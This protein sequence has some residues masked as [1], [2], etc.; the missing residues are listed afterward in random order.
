MEIILENVANSFVNGVLDQKELIAIIKKH[1]PTAISLAFCYTSCSKLNDILRAG[2]IYSFLI[3]DQ[4][5]RDVTGGKVFR[6]DDTQREIIEKVAN[7][8]PRYV[9]LW[10]SSGTGKTLTAFESLTIMVTSMKERTPKKINVFVTSFMSD[11]EETPLL[12]DLK[13]QYVPHLRNLPGI[14][15]IIEP[16]K[17]LCQELKIPPGTGV[18]GINALFEAIASQYSSEEKIGRAHV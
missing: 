14:K 2:G 1:N 16:F 17:K 3:L 9:F 4:E 6:C 11:Y 10:G 12:H 15:V 8:N 5:M 18:Q 7:Q 13:D